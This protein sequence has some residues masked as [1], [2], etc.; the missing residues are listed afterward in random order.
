MALGI[1]LLVAQ[2]QQEH[3]LCRIIV[4]EYDSE[5]TREQMAVFNRLELLQ[6]VGDSGSLS[7]LQQYQMCFWSC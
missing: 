6:T 7:S 4:V 1:W 2:I 5:M 3:N